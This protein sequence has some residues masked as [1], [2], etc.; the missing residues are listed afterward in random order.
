MLMLLGL[1]PVLILIHTL[2]PK[3]TEIEVTNLFLW[4][5]VLKERSRNITLKRLMKNLPLLLQILIVI[6]AAVALAKPVWTYL[7][8]QKGDMVFIVD[9]SASMRT[10]TA[11]GNRLDKAK[12]Q[13]TALIDDGSD[14]QKILI[15]EAG[16]EPQIQSG[17]VESKSRAKEIINSLMVTD[18]PGNIEKA[19]YLALSFVDP[20]KEDVIYLVTDGAGTRTDIKRV[21][22]AHPQIVPVGITGGG[23]NM[24]ITKFE[25]RQEMLRKNHYE[26]MLEV[27]NFSKDAIACPVQLSI[28]KT[29]IFNT[30]LNFEAFE[31]K[32]LIFPY[33]GLITGMA[34]ARLDIDDA[35]AADNRA[36]LS[37]NTTQD[38]WVLLVTKGN[39]FLEKLLESY[40]NFMVNTV[41]EIVPSSWDAQTRRHD[42]VII[43][44]MDFPP[45]QRGNFLL[46]N[47]FSPSLPASKEGQ[48]DF[49]VVLDWNNKSPLMT[50][51]NIEG[52]TIEKA[53]KIDNA[54]NL[55]KVI[56]S[57]ETGL[58]YTYERDGIRTVLLNFDITRSDLP[59]KVAFPVMMSNIINWLNPHKL[60]FSSLYTQAGK[61]FDIYLDPDTTSVSIRR[62]SGK[63]EKAVV[64]SNPFIYK[65][66]QAVGVYTIS[67]KNKRRYFT[68]NLLNEAESDITEVDLSAS[69]GQPGAYEKTATQQPYWYV[70]MLLGFT[71]LILEWFV[72]LKTE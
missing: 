53:F 35:L 44:R 23:A 46:I 18:A 71:I 45:S 24:G 6:L 50:D 30:R 31:K 17:F 68:V 33:S 55:T 67:E 25:F 41:R 54:V 1:I 19:V 26:I 32:L 48:I 14:D 2:K 64:Q 63:W 60:H 42:I 29:A 66:T 72:W 4:Q 65:N 12:Q 5:E 70:F 38:V 7:V 52:L 16:S 37:L 49:P 11:S 51:V 43:D 39:Y 3:P 36:Y 40:P 34:K 9:T 8:A 58:M 15:I 62:P 22:Q 10:Q 59:L 28:D 47:A 27:K 57:V 13:A 56:E 20:S 69:S 21:L 61:P